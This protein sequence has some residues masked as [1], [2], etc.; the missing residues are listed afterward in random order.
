MPFSLTNA[1]AVFQQFINEVLG[2][3]L[4]V[5]VIGYLDDILVYS[6][7][8]D[9]HQE[10]RLYVNP[11]KCKFHTDTVE[12]LGFILTLTG[13][14][15]DPVKVAAIQSWPEP[16]N[17]HNVQSFLR[18]ANFYCHF[19]VEYS[20]L[21]LPLTN[22]CKK[23]TPWVFS[24]REVTTFQ[25]LKNA[26][27]TAPVLCHWAPD[28]QMMVEMDMSNHAIAGIL[29]VTTQEDEIQPVAFFSHSLQGAE[30]NYDTHDKELLAMFEAFK[31]WQHFLEGSAVVIDT[32]TDHK[33]LEY[34][35]SS[36]KLLCR[37]ARWAEFLGQFNMKVQFRLGRL[38]S[39][40][41]TLTCRWDVYMEGNNPEPTATNVCP[42]F[43][44]EQLAGTPVLA[45]AGT[46]EDPTPSN[47]LDHDALA[48]S[49]TTAYAEDD[50]A[51][52]IREQIKTANQLDG[53]TER[54]GCLLFRERKYIPN[55]GMLRL[56]TI[57]DHHDHPT[58]GHFGETK[59]TELICCNYHW[60]G[61]R[62]MVGDY[63]RSC[64]SSTCTKAMHHK[65]Y[66][67]LKQLPIPANPWAS[68]LMH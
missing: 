13:L 57:R 60:P 31:N 11:K 6:D 48:E 61:L 10:A 14:P 42:V 37:Q 68:I 62:C 67:L 30:K 66:G 41:D 36:K 18:F 1:P 17:I 24:K 47:N 9:Q 16:Q 49:I 51:K 5:C 45:R 22:L 3:L 29:L 43:T 7:S 27:S 56:H 26:F 20:Q 40:P 63:I 19:I 33:N 58:A 2:N 34:F 35:T 65:P 53:W 4:D 38:G 55:K 52:K 21:T 59:T 54:E 25:T 44:I 50:L 32:V 64:T 39:K 12:Y 8:V 46:M 23:A 28:L 15:M